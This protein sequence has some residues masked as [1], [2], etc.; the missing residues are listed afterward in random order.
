MIL[1]FEDCELDTDRFELRRGGDTVPV[2]PQVFEKVGLGLHLFR[3]DFKLLSVLAADRDFRA[4]VRDQ[5]GLHR[6]AVTTDQ[7]S[8]LTQ[9]WQTS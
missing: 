8:E 6:L 3:V 7:R 4:I 1:R 2:E 5:L 9:T